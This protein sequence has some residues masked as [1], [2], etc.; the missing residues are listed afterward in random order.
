MGWVVVCGTI[1]N[2]TIT[3]IF[4]KIIPKPSGKTSKYMYLLS[5]VGWD[6]LKSPRVD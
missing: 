1:F 3:F 6:T 4:G 5:E 2:F